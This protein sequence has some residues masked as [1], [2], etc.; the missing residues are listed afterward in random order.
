MSK[1]TKITETETTETPTVD[2]QGKT[3]TELKEIAETLQAQVAHHQ[4][5]SVKAQGALEVVLQMIPQDK[6][7]G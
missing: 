2:F 4:T 5:M 6:E 1:N 3:T 7:E